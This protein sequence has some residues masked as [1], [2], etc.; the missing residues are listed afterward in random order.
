MVSAGGGYSFSVYD[1][2]RGKSI[3]CHFPAEL[4]PKVLAAFEKRVCVS[5]LI[6]YTG[7]GDIKSVEVEDFEVFPDPEQLPGF[8]DIFGLFGGAD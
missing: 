2:V 4:V 5:G 7:R 6:R 8:E 3:S 1:D